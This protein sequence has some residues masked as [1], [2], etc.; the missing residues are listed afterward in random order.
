MTSK[1]Y[2]EDF[3]VSPRFLPLNLRDITFLK[4]PSNEVLNVHA[5]NKKMNK[6]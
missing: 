3:R 1:C 2:I 5:T 4:V 6:L